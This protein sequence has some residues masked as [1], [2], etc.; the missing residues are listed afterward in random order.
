MKHMGAKSVYKYLIH[1]F[2]CGMMS[3]GRIFAVY[4]AAINLT[5]SRIQS[6]RTSS[7]NTPRSN[8]TANTEEFCCYPLG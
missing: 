6:V 5:E 7:K 3:L 4:I 2:G 8:S 1:I